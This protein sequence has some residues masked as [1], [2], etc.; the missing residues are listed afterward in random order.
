MKV[1]MINIPYA[2][3]TNPTL[4]L[5]KK[6]VQRGHEVYYINA[7]EF[8][9]KIEST[10]V[11]FIPYIHYPKAPTVQQKKTKCFRAAFD[12]ALQLKEKFDILIYEMFFFPGIKIAEILQIPCVRQFSQ[13]AWNK[14][15]I[16]KASR[17][18]KFTCWLINL[19]ILGRKNA[20]YMKLKNKS[21]TEAVINDSPDL[22]VVYVL[23]KFQSA[24]DS[25]SNQYLFTVPTLESLIKDD[26]IPFDKMKKPIVYFSLG[27]IISSRRLYRKCIKAFADKP[28]SVIL[29]TGKINPKSLGILPK[30]I[31]AFSFVPQIQV[32]Q[33]SDVFITHCGMNSVN[34]AIANG[35]PMVAIPFVND[36]ISN[37]NRIEEL[38][39]GK[40]LRLF[41]CSRKKLYVSV[42][43]VL[44][45]EKYKENVKKL[46]FGKELELEQVVQRIESLVCN[47]E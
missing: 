22:N 32:L 13:P 9:S 38:G 24:R 19:Q 3:H 37:A 2:G 20:E 41:S 12:T 44:Q 46:Q 4:P 14:N 45:N 36:Q 10:G 16:E 25:F 6:L 47:Q 15:N 28:M 42:Q 40:K 11:T 39:I 34:E 27:S 26:T 35:V 5:A 23:E 30:N 43:A 31:Y 17:F 33:R 18:F 7:E 21:L 29:N 1:L 8:R